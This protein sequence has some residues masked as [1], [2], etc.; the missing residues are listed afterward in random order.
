MRRLK[1]PIL[2]LGTL[3]L[4]AAFALLPR[5]ISHALD[6][7]RGNSPAY[8]DI[9]SVQL[10][11]SA[12]EN[13]LTTVDKLALLSRAETV[14]IRQ[15]QAA[16][17]ESE[18]YEVI[19]AFFAQLESTGICAGF[20]PTQFSIE[21]KLVYDLSDSFRNFTLW[22]ASFH[23][24][25]ATKQSLLLDIDDETGQILCVRYHIYRSYDMKGVWKRNKELMDLFTDLYFGQLGLSEAAEGIES[26]QVADA[27]DENRFLYEYNEVDGG[28]SEAVYTF[29]SPVFGQFRI[30][31]NV[32]GAGGFRVSF[33]Q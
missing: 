17:E 19:Q 31:I 5:F 11:L 24:E 18:V 1:I 6:L 33:W 4:L 26:S 30:H 12:D 3:G 28:V 23:C 9:H 20:E 25:D 22:T 7:R 13:T 21:P 8:T 27:A 2:I 14:N 10:D 16:M 32:D 15:D 29:D